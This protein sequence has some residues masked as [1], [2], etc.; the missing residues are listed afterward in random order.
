MKTRVIFYQ[1]LILFFTLIMAASHL[2]GQK[3]LQ[4]ANDLYNKGRELVA[5]K[6]F[7]E[8]I[9]SLDECIV[10][11]AE[12]ERGDNEEEILQA[13]TDLKQ[14][15]MVVIPALWRDH[16]VDL[17]NNK[18]NEEAIVAFRKAI[19]IS[20]K[21]NDIVIKEET[22]KSLSQLF[23]IAG[24]DLYRDKNYEEAIEWFKKSVELD[25]TN[26]QTLLLLGDSYRRLEKTPE[27]VEYFR[28][29]IDAARNPATDRSAQQASS[30]LM[31][32]YMITGAQ[33]I[34]QKNVAD[35]LANLDTAATFGQ[36]GDLY[37]YYSVGYYADQKYDESI[38]ASE[39]AIDLDSNNRENV[40]KYYF[41]IGQAY[42]A[43]KDNDKA[44]D[45]Y[46]KAN[47]G[48]TTIKADQMLKALKCK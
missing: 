7:V 39:K 14:K 5:E 3:T 19:E 46:K 40:A 20:T 23:L 22:E 45:A 8:A 32:H 10:I 13:I 35:G 28:K 6:K 37:Y 48:R 36:S 43:K 4:D 12:L 38:G 18:K 33:L 41:E 26:T 11:C 24:N 31:R 1:P 17:Y 21:Q 2:Y 44:C 47:F 25:P 27:M 42:Y 30:A 29:T 15:A 16:A 9:S 34:N